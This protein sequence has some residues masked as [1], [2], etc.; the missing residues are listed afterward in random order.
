MTH[1]KNSLRDRFKSIMKLFNDRTSK[2]DDSI[3]LESLEPRVMFDASPLAAAIQEIGDADVHAVDLEVAA[4]LQHLTFSSSTDDQTLADVVDRM[5]DLALDIDHALD[6]LSVLSADVESTG[7]VETANSIFDVGLAPDGHALNSAANELVVVDSHVDGYDQ[8]LADLEHQIAAGRNLEI[9]LLDGSQ[10]G[11]TQVSDFLQQFDRVD[12][13]QIISHGGETGFQL[14]S[15]WITGDQLVHYSDQITQWQ[16]VLSDSADISIYGCNLA[17]SESGQSLLNELAQLT[18]ADI[19]ASDDLTGHTSLGGD[20]DLE[21]VIGTVDSH[22]AFSLDVQ[23]SWSGVLDST[24]LSAS[25]D[26]Y[27]TAS[28]AGANYGSS[29]S[30]IIDRESGDLQRALLQFDISSIASDADIQSATLKLQSTAIDGIITVGVYE[31]LEN[32]SEGIGNGSG[33]TASWNQ[34]NDGVNWTTAGGYFDPTALDTLTTDTTGQH[35]W[36]VTA[37]VADWVS[38]SKTNNGI[39]VLS[40]DGGGNRTVTYDSRE[41]MVMPVLEIHYNGNENEG[42]ALWSENGTT[43]PQ[44]SHFNGITFGGEGN[45]ANVDQWEVIQGAD[46]HTRDET[47]VIGIDSGKAIRGEMWN[48]ST[49]SALPINDLGAAKNIKTW[50]FDV[51]YESQSDDA[52]LVW[53]DSANLEFS[54]WDGSAWTTPATVAAYDGVEIQHLHLAADPTTDEMVLAITDNNGDDYAL[55]WNGSSWGNRILLNTINSQSVTDVSVAYEHQSGDAIVVYAKDTTDVFYRTW[56]GSSWSS[57]STLPAPMGLGGKARWT[58]MDSDPNSD[59]IVLGVLTEAEDAYFAVW[60][61]NTWAAGDRLSAT[62]DTNDRTY[63]NISVAFETDSGQALIAY[64]AEDSVVRYRTWTDGSGWSGELAGPDLGNKPTSMT[65]SS[66][67]TSDRIML[68]ALDEGK[69][70]SYVQWDGSSWGT[71]DQQE[72]NTG[73]SDAQPF[74]Y[75]WNEKVN[76]APTLDNSPILNLDPVM[77][78]AGSAGGR[79]RHTG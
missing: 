5:N 66:D 10:D 24:I 17:A 69:S 12:S 21:F 48:G 51:A 43:T 71:P 65:L 57:E 22:L 7:I 37:L 27:I 67:P 11:V 59:R 20:W 18:G 76:E 44:Y 23:H 70:V 1:A 38:G 35:T 75:L 28:A 54:V 50:S 16:S 41:G 34:R 15:S 61:G 53:G 13:L 46:S 42:L 47:I 19:A 79:G 4:D 14:G 40:A 45:S 73:Q 62:S 58:M 9:L 36:D 77:E 25:Q 52:V 74:V 68:S 26:T 31:L 63:P 33:D 72:I 64:G 78:D 30:L 60:D 49:W 6:L 32:W 29:T 55:V 39:I 56:D 2:R 3:R 8:L